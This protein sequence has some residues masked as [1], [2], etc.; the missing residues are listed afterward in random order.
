MDYLVAFFLLLGALLV[1]VGSIG[2]MRMPDFYMRLHTPTKATTVGMGSLLL[3]SGLWF[4]VQQQAVSVH[5]ILITLLL[6]ITAP[7]TAHM[8]AKSALQK[9][10]RSEEKTEGLELARD[11]ANRR[12][13]KG[14]QA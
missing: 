6:F 4:T 7:V 11:A 3:A 8:L 13:P 12:P 1:L 14:D 5:E 9:R 2:L 10:V